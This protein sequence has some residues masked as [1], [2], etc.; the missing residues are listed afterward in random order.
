MNPLETIRAEIARLRRA[1]ADMEQ[2]IS[3]LEQSE[4]LLEPVYGRVPLSQ[5][6][7]GLGPLITEDAGLTDKIR[8]LLRASFPAAI[9][10]T[11]IRDMLVSTGQ[12]TPPPSERSNFLAEIHNVLKRLV[13][14]GDAVEV[15]R[16]GGKAYHAVPTSGVGTPSPRGR[17]HAPGENK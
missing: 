13:T 17:L 6:L 9:A 16:N 14:Q 15:L 10:P 5:L 1:K 11:A 4:K 8:E 7:A 12:I 3:A 2:Q